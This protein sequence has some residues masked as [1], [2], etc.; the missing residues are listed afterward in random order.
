MVPHSDEHNENEQTMAEAKEGERNHLRALPIEESY[1]EVFVQY[2][3]PEPGREGKT[4]GDRA[5]EVV[6]GN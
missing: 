2:V 5:P 6:S 3:P 1:G 4:V